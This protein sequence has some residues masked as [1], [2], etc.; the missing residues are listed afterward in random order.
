M[1]ANICFVPW[2]VETQITLFIV[3]TLV[4]FFFLQTNE[5]FIIIIHGQIN[6][7]KYFNLDSFKINI[8]WVYIERVWK[9]INMYIYI[10]I[11]TITRVGMSY[12]LYYTG[13]E[14]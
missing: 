3:S 2:S 14:K 1:L 6:I 11:L 4:G 9:M 7:L 8:F 5:M 13:I 12:T 10:Y